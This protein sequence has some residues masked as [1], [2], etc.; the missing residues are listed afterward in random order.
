MSEERHRRSASEPSGREKDI[1]DRWMSIRF[2]ERS[3]GDYHIRLGHGGGVGTVT[4]RAELK[5]QFGDCYELQIAFE[6][7]EQPGGA[8][9]LLARLNELEV[10]PRMR[11][12]PNGCW[13]YDMRG[14]FRRLT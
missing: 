4:Y 6:Q 11:R 8:S 14:D 13:V 9:E 3:A 2:P 5:N 12:L 10:G 7:F 1:V